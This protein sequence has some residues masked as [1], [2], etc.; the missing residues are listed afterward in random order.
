MEIRALVSEDVCAVQALLEREYTGYPYPVQ[1]R[2]DYISY[3]AVVDSRIVGFAR[4][5]RDPYAVGHVYEFGT[6]I[7]D[8]VY[9][10]RGMMH[11]LATKI[12]AEGWERGATWQHTEM[13]TYVPGI[14]RIL[15]GVGFHPCGIELAKHPGLRDTMPQPESVLFG[16][17]R[18][19][20]KLATHGSLFLPEDYREIVHAI[21]RDLLASASPDPVGRLPAPAEHRAYERDGKRGSDFIDVA[22]NTP[23]AIGII[24]G[25]RRN[26]WS[27]SGILPGLLTTSTGAPCDGL[28]LQ[29]LPHRQHFDPD[30]VQTVD[31]VAAR[32]RPYI[33]ADLQL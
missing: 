1:C 14:Q 12:T 3:V 17:A 8:P 28:R 21:D 29:R 13:V 30:L 19:D 6:A 9:R 2:P 20:G 25:L 11:A 7:V 5:K 18:H 10:V 32:M 24:Q 15:P 16:L 23:D 33:L 27:F 4:A 26:G 31:P 22:V